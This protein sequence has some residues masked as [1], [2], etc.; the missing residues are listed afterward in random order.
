MIIESHVARLTKFDP[1]GKVT[2]V[3][4]IGS[5][6][7]VLGVT[8]LS[9]LFTASGLRL[10]L[11]EPDVE[12]A[13]ADVLATPTRMLLTDLAARYI[14]QPFARNLLLMAATTDGSP[15]AEMV[16]CDLDEFPAFALT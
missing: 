1:V 8:L 16:T 9:A 12:C 11:R 10:V 4:T 14:P 2:G 3:A 13:I 5:H 7:C 15:G 6:V